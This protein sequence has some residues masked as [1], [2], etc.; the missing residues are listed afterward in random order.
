VWKEPDSNFTGKILMMLET[1]AIC[2]GRD[3]SFIRSAAIRQ[4]TQPIQSRNPETVS[5]IAV[6]VRSFGLSRN[7]AQRRS[8]LK[9]ELQTRFRFLRLLLITSSDQSLSLAR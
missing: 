9:A 7:P 4:E 1:R 2:A 3:K 6:N 8:R 5:K